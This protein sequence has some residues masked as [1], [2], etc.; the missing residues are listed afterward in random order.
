M[1]DKIIYIYIYI[2]ACTVQIWRKKCFFKAVKSLVK[3]LLK[4]TLST[5]FTFYL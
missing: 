4:M 2:V 3:V 1:Y 5:P